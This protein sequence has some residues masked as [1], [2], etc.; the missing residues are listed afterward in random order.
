MNED[1]T[2]L[3]HRDDRDVLVA[4]GMLRAMLAN[5]IANA[6]E[7]L[8]GR[9]LTKDERVAALGPANTRLLASLNVLD[10]LAHVE[11]QRALRD[12]L[13]APPGEIIL[14]PGTAVACM[15]QTPHAHVQQMDVQHASEDA[16]EGRSIVGVSIT[17]VVDEPRPTDGLN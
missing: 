6:L 13:H 4:R 9:A 16:G 11:Y 15:A 17:P 7:P 1:H 5:S 14:V 2:E 10:Q 12:E 8:I 3:P